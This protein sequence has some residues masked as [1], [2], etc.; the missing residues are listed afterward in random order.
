MTPTLEQEA[1]A[2]FIASGQYARHV[3]ATGKLY[4]SRRSCMVY[5][6]HR[7]FQD[8]VTTY[9]DEAGLHLL[10]QLNTEVDEHLMADKALGYGV[11]VYP[12]SEYFVVS[13]P[14]NASFLLGY[15]N[16]TEYQI[17]RGIEL[18]AQAEGLCTMN[19]K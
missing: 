9:G 4:G 14:K 8:R 19:T 7:Y 12:A 18:L 10:I 13:K 11:K 6:L 1:L 15:A 5:S 3:N 2:E 16:M 17:Q